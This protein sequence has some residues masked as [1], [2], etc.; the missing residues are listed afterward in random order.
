MQQQEH[1]VIKVMNWPSALL[2]DKSTTDEHKFGHLNSG[3]IRAP[4]MRKSQINSVY[5]SIALMKLKLTLLNLS[6]IRIEPNARL[7]KFQN[8]DSQS[9]PSSQISDSLHLKYMYCTLPLHSVKVF[10]R[11]Q[12]IHLL[13]RKRMEVQR[14]RFFD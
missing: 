7:A 8:T 10:L 2:D 13:A 14:T 11:F 1:E 4:L 3:C 12:Y 6:V 5:Q 9:D